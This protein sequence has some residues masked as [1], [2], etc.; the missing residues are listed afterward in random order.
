MLKFVSFCFLSGIGA[1]G[2]SSLYTS[3]LLLFS[4][5]QGLISWARLP[6]YHRLK[7]KTSIMCFHRGISSVGKQKACSVA[8]VRVFIRRV[9]LGSPSPWTLCRAWPRWLTCTILSGCTWAER[10]LRGVCVRERRDTQDRQA[11]R[12]WLGQVFQASAHSGSQGQSCSLL[13][14]AELG[15]RG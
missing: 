11:D 14:S 12:H 13:A 5:G 4:L 10:D 7:W 8:V 3:S 1:F 6:F 9:S 2:K 15:E